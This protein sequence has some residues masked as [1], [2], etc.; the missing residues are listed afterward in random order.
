MYNACELPSPVVR[1]SK[2][3]VSTCSELDWVY[4]VREELDEALA[5]PNPEAQAE[6][7]VDAMTVCVSWLN[8]LG[9]DEQGR[10]AIYRKVNTKNRNRGYME[11][12]QKKDGHCMKNNMEVVPDGELCQTDEA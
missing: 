8:A 12:G 3:N 2:R 9:Y 6:E 7:I 5:A 4:R 1:D 10:A 11:A